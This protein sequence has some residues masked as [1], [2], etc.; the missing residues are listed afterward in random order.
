MVPD[1]QQLWLNGH[2]EC[3]VLYKLLIQKLLFF[4]KA[5]CFDT[6]PTVFLLEHQSSITTYTCSSSFMLFVKHSNT[7]SFV[8]NNRY[9]GTE[10]VSSNMQYSPNLKAK[11]S[12]I[13]IFKACRIKNNQLNLICPEEYINC[14]GW[15]SCVWKDN[16]HSLERVWNK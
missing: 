14:I 7:L 9:F 3:D 11:K 6:V 15:P 12:L 16:D 13:Y 10:K 2:S 5:A 1:L 4:C 8:F